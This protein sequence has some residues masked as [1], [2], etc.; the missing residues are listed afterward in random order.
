MISA[1]NAAA[2]L[3]VLNAAM[4]AGLEA[5][6]RIPSPEKDRF[7]SQMLS[8]RQ[9]R[10]PPDIGILRA[11]TSRR[12]EGLMEHK[13][14]NALHEPETVPRVPGDEPVVRLRVCL[15]RTQEAVTRGGGEYRGIQ[16]GSDRKGIPDLVLFNDP[17]T[18]TTL[19]LILEEEPIT[20]RAIRLKIA[21]SRAMFAQYGN[22]GF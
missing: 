8:I 9:V 22:Y 18:G 16:R 6:L 7:S 12:G 3:S 20:P 1:N 15:D 19:A 2:W 14:H 5:I 4:S 21:R 11:F 10:V 17:I 13:N